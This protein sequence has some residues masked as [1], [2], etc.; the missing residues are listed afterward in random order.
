[1][2]HSRSTSILIA[3]VPA[4]LVT[5]VVQSLLSSGSS[6]LASRAC[7]PLPKLDQPV[8]L[9]P[10]DFSARINNR[11]WPMTAGSRWVYRVTDM[12]TGHVNHEV[13]QATHARSGWPTGS[14]CGSSAMS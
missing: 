8:N 4:A 10:A 5:L 1:M 3:V 12:E 13:I 11:R 9:D 2:K 7:P 6:A 14:W